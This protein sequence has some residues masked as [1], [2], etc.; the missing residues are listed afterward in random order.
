MQN[1]KPLENL[2]ALVAQLETERIPFR[3]EENEPITR[4]SSF[5]PG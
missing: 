4:S 3:K 5:F 1:Y 2:A